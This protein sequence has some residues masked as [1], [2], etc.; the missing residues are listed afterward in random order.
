VLAQAIFQLRGRKAGKGNLEQHGG[1]SFARRGAATD[2]RDSIAQSHFKTQ[3]AKALG[4]PLGPGPNVFLAFEQHPVNGKR[5]EI[6][7]SLVLGQRP[8]E[9]RIGKFVDSADTHEWVA[10]DSCD[11][12]LFADDDACLRPAHQLVAA[13][14]D[15]VGAGGQGFVNGRFVLHRRMYDF[16]KEAAASILDERDPSMPGKQR[17]V[18]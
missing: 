1:N 6:I 14:T 2:Q 16:A 17:Q 11:Q 8:V 4:Q 13:K 3:R 9:D 7:A 5:L 18:P 12:I 10:P 15:K